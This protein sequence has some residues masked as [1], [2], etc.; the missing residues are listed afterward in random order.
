MKF[1]HKKK[2]KCLSF[3]YLKIK[4]SERVKKNFFCSFLHNK[5][6]VKNLMRKNYPIFGCITRG[7]SEFKSGFYTKKQVCGLCGSAGNTA[8]FDIL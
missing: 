3:S 1:P 8:N 4:I 5:N 7:L 2:S 6:L